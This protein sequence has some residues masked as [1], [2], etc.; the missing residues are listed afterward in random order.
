MYEAHRNMNDPLRAT[1]GLA[2]SKVVRTRAKG[3]RPNLRT[4]QEAI[5]LIENDL[6]KELRV[7][8][9]WSFAHALLLEAEKSG[10]KRDLICAER[11]LKQALSNEGW[12]AA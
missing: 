11:Q 8:S 3:I 9:R 6:P 1:R 4:V 2:L 10:K 7:L 12:L 5:G